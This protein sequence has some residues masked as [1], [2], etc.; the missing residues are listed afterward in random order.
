ML[1]TLVPCN[2]Y[3]RI[4]FSV[5]LHMF[6]FSYEADNTVSLWSLFI[7]HPFLHIYGGGVCVYIY[8]YK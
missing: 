5:K 8:V 6:I 4:M 7:L 3:R 2:Y 1:K